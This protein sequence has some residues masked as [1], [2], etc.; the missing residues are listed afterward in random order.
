MQKKKKLQKMRVF[1]KTITL[2][3]GEA[4]EIAIKQALE[5]TLSEITTA[6]N[7]E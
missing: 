3:Y 4:L 7:D 2:A 1:R 5:E 6:L